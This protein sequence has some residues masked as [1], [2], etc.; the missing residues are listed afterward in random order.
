MAEEYETTP[1]PLDFDALELGSTVPAEE[2]AEAVFAKDGLRPHDLNFWAAALRVKGAVENH[3]LEERGAVVTVCTDHGAIRILTHSEALAYNHRARQK[4]AKGM[5]RTQVRTM[6]IDRA[7]LTEGE[8]QQ[9]D[10]DTMRNSYILQ[11]FK[12]ARTMKLPRSTDSSG[13]E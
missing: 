8:R 4:H 9:H 11:A 7:A 1:Y 13:G 2:V 3:F 6:G 12:K 5:A 10:K